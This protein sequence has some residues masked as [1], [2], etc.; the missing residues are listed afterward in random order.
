M[1]STR[2]AKRPRTRRVNRVVKPQGTF[3]PRVQ[4]VG[5]EHFGIVTVDCAKVRSKWMLAD[6]Y[7]NVRVPPTV[8]AHNRADLDAAIT[9]LRAAIEK[10]EIRDLLVAVERTGRY[11]HVT[12]RAFAAAG[13]ETRV[14]HPFATKQFR[15]P[16]NPGNK[17]DDT[18]L[19]A[20]HRAAVNGFALER[21][22]ARLRKDR[23]R[24]LERT[25]CHVLAWA[26]VAAAPDCAA[27]THRQIALTLE[28]DRQEKERKIQAL[29]RQLAAKLARTEYIVLLS[30]PGINVVSAAEYAGEMGPIT[31]YANPK[32]ITGRAGLYPS[33]A[34][35]DQVDHA[36]GPLTRC[37]NRQL[38]YAI[39]QIAA[40]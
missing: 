5:P 22:S 3:H 40:V 35:S 9:Q 14:V 24:C 20:I 11:H 17:T 28:D 6:F 19:A 27:E 4:K 36:D 30:I 10:Q 25:L 32:T 7:G 2:T 16:A 38:R 26:E 33:R 21:L 29:E 23:I 39:L 13:F 34:Q 37:A 12:Q 15:Q 1:V 18:D 8:V 31:R